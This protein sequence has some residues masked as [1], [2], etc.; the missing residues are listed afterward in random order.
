MA[1]NRK[2]VIRQPPSKLPWIIAT[3][4]AIALALVLTLG[5]QTPPGTHP[6][7]RADAANLGE[8]VMPASFFTDNPMVV[9]TYQAAR[10]IPATLDGIYCYCHCRENEGHR[11]LLTCFQS[12][13][14]AGCDVCLEE[15]QMAHQLHAQGRSLEDIR[16]QIDL[17]FGR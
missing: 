13:H 1:T 3:V 5:R 9:R 2:R 6:E 10:E 14:G 15:A 7:P 16:A 4:A 8:T 12:Q 17:A 11:S